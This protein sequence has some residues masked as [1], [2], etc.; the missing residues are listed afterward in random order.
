MKENKIIKTVYSFFCIIMAFT[1]ILIIFDPL[2]IN[3][4]VEGGVKVII[5][6][7]LIFTAIVFAL[8]IK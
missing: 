4:V 8:S 5:G 7:S 6:I 3:V 2:Q 1:G